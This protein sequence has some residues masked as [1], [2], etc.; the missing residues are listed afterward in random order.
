MSIRADV[1]IITWKPSELH[2]KLKPKKLKSS[3][4]MLL[5][6]CQ[7]CIPDPNFFSD[8]T[9]HTRTAHPTS[10][11][12]PPQSLSQGCPAK[13]QNRR[14]CVLSPLSPPRPSRDSHPPPQ[15]SLKRHARLKSSHPHTSSHPQNCRRKSK[16][17][18]PTL[19]AYPPAPP[20]TA[21]GM[22]EN[23]HFRPEK[24]SFHPPESPDPAF[25]PL[26]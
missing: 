20:K 18:I 1:L 2:K 11:T 26:L 24:A 12:H 22:R 3:I 4:M 14:P 6:C 16:A 13:Y 8:P 23:P 21:P 5:G 15:T 25:R 17:Q 10:N 19:T 7:S 9:D